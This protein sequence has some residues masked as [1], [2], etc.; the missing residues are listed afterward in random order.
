MY[1]T[2]FFTEGYMHTTSE[3]GISVSLKKE[4]LP[5]AQSASSMAENALNPLPHWVPPP[6]SIPA[7]GPP[8]RIKNHSCRKPV[9]DLRHCIYSS[10]Y[11]THMCY[12]IVWCVVIAIRYRFRGHSLCD[13]NEAGCGLRDATKKPP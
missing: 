5:A 6:P 1:F 11:T 13:T 9:R 12:M 7:P 4:P 2:H 10:V 3:F 8:E